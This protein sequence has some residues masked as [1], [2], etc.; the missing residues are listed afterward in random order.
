MNNTVAYEIKEF[1]DRNIYH[2]LTM[3][4]LA[5]QASLSTSQVN[6]VF[7]KEFNQTPYDY[8]LSQKI[9]TAKLLLQNTNIPIKQIAYKLNFADEHYFSNFFKEKCGVSPKDYGK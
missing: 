7:K 3:E 8:I 2:K 4:I 5:K 9:A 6:R 1:I